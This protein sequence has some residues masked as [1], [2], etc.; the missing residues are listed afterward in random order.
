R[1][2]PAEGIEHVVVAV[3]K[4]QKRGVIA[5]ILQAKPAGQTL[6]FT[7]TKYG[8]DKLVT[9]L[10]REAFRRTPFTA[11]RPRATAP[12]PWTRSARAT[13]TCWSRPI[14][15][16]GESTWTES[17]WS[18]ISTYRTTPKCTCTASA[19]RRGP[20]RGGSP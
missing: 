18:S 1:A 9:F 3:D 11:T 2:K 12:G 10:R 5:R 4:L 16:L 7:R 17:A 14:S 20:A 15:R 6:V 13:R 8:A 19:A